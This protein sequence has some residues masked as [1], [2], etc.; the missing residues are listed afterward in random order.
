M[1]DGPR[2][3]RRKQANPRRKNGKKRPEPNFSGPLRGSR[4][5]EKEGER[6]K[7]PRRRRRRRPGLAGE[8]PSAAG[9]GAQ[10]ARRLRWGGVGEVLG[11]VGAGRR[12]AP[13][14]GV[15]PGPRAP[16]PAVPSRPR[17]LSSA[18][19]SARS[20]PA[21]S[22]AGLRER[23]ARAGRGPGRQVLQDPGAGAGVAEGPRGRERGPR[24]VPPRGLKFLA[25]V[26]RPPLRTPSNGPRAAGPGRARPDSVVG[27]TRPTPRGVR[28][29]PRGLG[30][31]WLLSSGL[32]PLIGG[33][34]NRRAQ[35]DFSGQF[36]HG[37]EEPVIQAESGRRKEM[38]VRGDTQI[39]GG[40]LK[41]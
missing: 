27:G 34:R 19:R 36:L 4:P 40:R 22:P 18:S 30:D 39:R 15:R 38:G 29:V 2:C 11:K 12:G 16:I 3:K 33:W 41:G 35:G 25:G 20:R 26:A 5:R 7:E 9:A 6:E 14:A 21:W 32:W 37:Q 13:S 1:A 31:G 17:P 10:R 28:R 8:P 24:A 23:P